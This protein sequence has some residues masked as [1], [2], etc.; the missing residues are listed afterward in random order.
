MSRTGVD[1]DL[2]REVQVF[3][4]GSEDVGVVPGIGNVFEKENQSVRGPNKE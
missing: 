4:I 2:L 1:Y 3:I